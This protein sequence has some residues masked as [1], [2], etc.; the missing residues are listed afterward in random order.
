MNWTSQKNPNPQG[1]GV[2]ALT[3]L[4]DETRPAGARPKA[5]SEFLFDWFVSALV[6]SSE[7][8]MKPSRGQDYYLYLHKGVWKLSLVAPHEWRGRDVGDCLG[9][10]YLRDD[11]TWAV[12]PDADLAQREDLLSELAG[13]VEG[14]VHNI[15]DEQALDDKLPGYRREMPY[16][17]RMFATGL[18]VSL[19]DSAAAS[20]VLG[21]SGNRLLRLA[22]DGFARRLLGGA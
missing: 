17:Q 5:P 21:E 9:L 3:A 2:V 8:R 13:L 11:M 19:R 10:C 6:L 18:G 14:F 20:G 7:F 16:F 1:K 22:G 4:W 12:E 15:G